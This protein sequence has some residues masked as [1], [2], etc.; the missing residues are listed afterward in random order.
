MC[1]RHLLCVRFQRSAVAACFAAAFFCGCGVESPQGD[2]P[3]PMLRAAKHGL[4]DPITQRDVETFLTIVG[5][6]PGERP[7]EFDP[8]SQATVTD[9]LSAHQLADVYR[10]EYRA[11]F[12]ASR[13]R[14]SMAS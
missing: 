8:L 6:L 7:P 2:A 9:H 3:T 11:M 1:V 10:Q 14:G 5:E 13:Q 12:D 4:S